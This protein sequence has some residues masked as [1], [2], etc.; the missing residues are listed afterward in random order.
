MGDEGAK[1]IKC[2]GW[3]RRSITLTAV[4]VKQ[5]KCLEVL[6]A[7]ENGLR[8]SQIDTGKPLYKTLE[9]EMWIPHKRV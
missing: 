3:I 5:Q 9:P 4:V 1:N 2:P 7:E 8:R 6:K